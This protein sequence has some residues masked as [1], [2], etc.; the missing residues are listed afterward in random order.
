MTKKSEA[1]AKVDS[2]KEEEQAATMEEEQATTMESSEEVSEDVSVST[3]E[4][5][6]TIR[7]HVY[8]SMALGL[9]PIPLLDLVGLSVIQLDL[10]R[11]IAK[12]YNVPF[13]EN[14]AKTCITALVGGVLPVGLAPVAA[15]IIKCVPIVGTLTGAVSMSLLGGASTYAV[16]RVFVKHFE[17]GGTLLDVDTE[18][19]QEGFKEQYEKG[20][21]YVAGLKKKEEKEPAP[22]T[23]TEPEAQAKA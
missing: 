4:I 6:R 2:V 21:E 11:K 18:K 22:K 12:K 15:S 14:A 1:T 17:S 23:E 7:N 5:D 13:K 16:G 3:E 9:A 20:K 10:V 8:S 19:V